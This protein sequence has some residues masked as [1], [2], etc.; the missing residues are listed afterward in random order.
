MAEDV[1]KTDIAQQKEIGK[2]FCSNCGAQ[3]DEKAVICPK[4]GV[5]QSAIG[6]AVG[7]G[8]KKNKTTAALLAFFLGGFGIHK[9]YLKKSNWWVYLVL[10][11]TAIP[12]L[13]ALVESIQL[14]MM[15]EADFDRQYNTS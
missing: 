5:A 11:W 13:I 8:G 6:L 14:F 4:C 7:M 12:A 2:K 3:I 1:N 9:L 10:C 15:S